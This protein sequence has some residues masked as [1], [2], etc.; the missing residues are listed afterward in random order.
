MKNKVKKVVMSGQLEFV[1]GGFAMNDEATPNY[2][3]ILLNL[4]K[5]H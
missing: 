3:D 1:N 4:Y 5:G 2:Q